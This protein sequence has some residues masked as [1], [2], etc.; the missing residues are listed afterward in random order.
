MLLC[1]YGGPKL[2][3]KNWDG[4]KRLCSNLTFLNYVAIA[5]YSGITYWRT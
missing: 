4:L 2:L 3:T 5:Q 1:T